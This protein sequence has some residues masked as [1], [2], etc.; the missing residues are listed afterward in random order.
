[1]LV[2]TQ[3]E[4]PGSWG[5]FPSQLRGGG[6][7]NGIWILQR[8]WA[9]RWSGGGAAPL[10]GTMEGLHSAGVEKEGSSWQLDGEAGCGPYSISHL[11]HPS[12]GAGG[13]GMGS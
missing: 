12:I 10:W 13:F 6:R 7:R 11:I 4:Q 1:M 5:P 2:S 8:G 9:E 3:I